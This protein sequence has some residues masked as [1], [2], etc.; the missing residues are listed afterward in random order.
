MNAHPLS[1]TIAM[2]LCFGC[3]PGMAPVSG[4]STTLSGRHDV[5]V[6]ASARIPLGENRAAP[7]SR[8]RGGMSPLAFFRRGLAGGW[9]VGLVLS[10]AGGRVEARHERELRG[11]STRVSFSYGTGGWFTYS[12]D[13]DGDSVPGGGLMV[14]LVF[15]VDIGGLYE[16]WSGS[17]SAMECQAGRQYIR[18][19]AL[20]GLAMGLRWLHVWM[21]LLAEYEWARAGEASPSSQWVLTPSF[22]IRARL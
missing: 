1:L 5:G 16:A 11:G 20:V 21:E 9:D 6:G 10:P 12:L 2:V 19:G 22:G 17:V 4:G 8:P 7:L 15:G 13:E 18:T 3:A 14:P